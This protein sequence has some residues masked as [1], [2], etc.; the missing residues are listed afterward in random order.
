MQLSSLFALG[1]HGKWG[2]DWRPSGGE[3]AGYAEGVLSSRN[4]DLDPIPD[5][6]SGS[7]MKQAEHQLTFEEAILG[8][9]WGDPRRALDLLF[10]AVGAD[11]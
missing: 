10:R 3:S 11:P 7:H 9:V 2:W 4:S 1:L 8:E 6:G 5:S